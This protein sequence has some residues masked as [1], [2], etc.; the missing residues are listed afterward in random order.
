MIALAP[1][2]T[3]EGIFHDESGVAKLERTLSVCAHSRRTVSQ[4]HFPDRL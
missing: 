1:E 4:A 2:I 3:G